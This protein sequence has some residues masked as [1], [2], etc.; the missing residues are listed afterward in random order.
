MRIGRLFAVSM[1]SVTALAVV[2]GA[3]VLVPQ[4]NTFASKTDAI[5]AVEAY[6]AVLA[7]GQ[8]IA[9][10]RA[11]YLSPLFQ[12]GAATPNQLEAIAKAVRQGM[13]LS[14]TPGRP[15]VL[16]AIAPRSS[17][18]SVGQRPSLAMSALRRTACWLCPECARCGCCQRLPARRVPG[19]SFG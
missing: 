2:Q 7:V 18:V 19:R 9:S 1:F 14:P 3:G 16:S 17:K 6:G 12:E 11:P 10:H 8:Q 5:K 4:Y 13:S 15:S